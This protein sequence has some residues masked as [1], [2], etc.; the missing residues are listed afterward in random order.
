MSQTMRTFENNKLSFSSADEGMVLMNKL[1][2][3][4]HSKYV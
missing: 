4:Y 1:I 2:N 3:V